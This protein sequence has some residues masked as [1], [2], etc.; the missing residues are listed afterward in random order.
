M[1]NILYS[2]NISSS[3]LKK[4]FVERKSTVKLSSTMK[5]K[6]ITIQTVHPTNRCSSCL[7][8]LPWI[9]SNAR[10]EKK[11]NKTKKQRLRTTTTETK[12][13]GLPWNIHFKGF[14]SLPFLEKKLSKVYLWLVARDGDNPV[15]RPRQRI[16]NL[17]G[18]TTTLPK[19]ST[20]V[21]VIP[22]K[23]NWW[24]K[25][26]AFPRSPRFWKQ[27]LFNIMET[28]RRVMGGW[29]KRSAPLSC[30]IAPKRRQDSLAINEYL[31]FEQ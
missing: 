31:K 19:N 13:Y 18:R 24:D 17:N 6:W 2:K 10:R 8:V 29:R 3:S 22:M 21:K 4:T 11:K 12:M 14:R 26:T 27:K 30:N 9:L 28:A 16:V 23:P 1:L 5:A 20:K 7:K 15:I 25:L